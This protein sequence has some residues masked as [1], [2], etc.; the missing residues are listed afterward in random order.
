MLVDL[1]PKDLGSG[2]QNCS[3][4]LGMVV[5]I[6]AWGVMMVKVMVECARHPAIRLRQMHKLIVV[7]FSNLTGHYIKLFASIF[8]KT[9]SKSLV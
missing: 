8:K 7:Y 4:T 5:V 1:E 3:A 9:F 2:E 6:L